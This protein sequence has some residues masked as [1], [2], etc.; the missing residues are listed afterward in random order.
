MPKSIKDPT[1]GHDSITVRL[2][3]LE[4]QMLLALAKHHRKNLSAY[5]RDVLNRHAQ[6]KQIKNMESYMTDPKTENKKLHF[7]FERLYQESSKKK[8]AYLRATKKKGGKK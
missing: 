1:A 7:L 4:K 8:R 6:D 5:C 3:E 2:S